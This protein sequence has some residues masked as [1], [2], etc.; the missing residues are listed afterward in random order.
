MY[1]LSGACG[2]RGL[3]NWM[4]GQIESLLLLKKN[5]SVFVWFVTNQ[6]EIA[7]NCLLKFILT[8]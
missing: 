6:R 7:E 1:V 3:N 8:A 4:P 2:C 5:K